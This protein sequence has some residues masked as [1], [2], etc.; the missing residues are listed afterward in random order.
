MQKVQRW[1][2]PFCTCRKARARPSKCPSRMRRVSL[3]RHDVVDATRSPRRR[4]FAV[5]L[6]L[7]AEHTVDFR[8][9]GEGAGSV[10]AAQPVTMMRASGRSRL[11]RRI[12]WR[13][14]RTASPVTA[15]VL[16]I[17]ALSSPLGGARGSPRI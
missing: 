12:A 1:S 3:H 15:Q 2:Q 9:R 5:E 6:F 8:H 7:I 11:R 17:T 16:T 10:C 4:K 13:D 14:W